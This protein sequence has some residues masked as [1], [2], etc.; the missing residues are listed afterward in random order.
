MRLLRK[1]YGARAPKAESTTLHD[2]PIHGV[3]T[4]RNDRTMNEGFMSDVNTLMDEFGCDPWDA[5]NFG[6]HPASREPDES[7]TVYPT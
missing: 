6:E 1:A 3:E 2:V 4:V 5:D 7:R